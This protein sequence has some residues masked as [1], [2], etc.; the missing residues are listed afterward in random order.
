MIAIKMFQSCFFSVKYSM[1]Q[2]YEE[3]VNGRK[4]L[5]ILFLKNNNFLTLSGPQSTP[6][7][8]LLII[9]MFVLFFHICIFNLKSLEVRSGAIRAKS[10]LFKILEKICSILFYSGARL[11][12]ITVYRTNIKNSVRSLQLFISVFSINPLSLD[13]ISGVRFEIIGKQKV[14]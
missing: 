12:G 3:Q 13:S 2:Q 8:R 4:D 14:C 9:K 5:I 10:L 6:L 7:K 11:N 1:A